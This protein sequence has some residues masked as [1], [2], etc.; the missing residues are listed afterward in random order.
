VSETSTRI[1]VGLG[2]PGSRYALT[3]HNVGFMVADALVRR[4]GAGDRRARFSAEVCECRHRDE[5]VVVLKPQ[6]FMNLSGTSVA[7]ALRWYKLP[8]EQ[9][10]VVHD[11]LDLPFGQLRIRPRGSAGGHNGLGSI[12]QE[13]GSQEIA[14]LRIGIGRP[15]FGDSVPY[16]LSRFSPEEEADL[17]A[18]I[19][20]AVEALI[21]W[22]DEGITEAMN[23][24]NRR[25]LLVSDGDPG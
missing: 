19:D 6:T 21:C 14:R 5:K 4:L 17:P 1:I 18:I 20:Q 25:D 22:L 7:A 3:R 8:L 11:D 24:F 15:A 10:I 23:R 16:V 2:N 13:L 12:V 9:A